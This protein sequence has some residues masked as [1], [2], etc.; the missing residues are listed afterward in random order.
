M[1]ALRFLSLIVC[2]AAESGSLR[3][4]ATLFHV[5]GDGR[6]FHRLSDNGAC[7]GRD[8]EDNNAEHFQVLQTDSLQDCREQCL[9]KL[10]GCKG[11]GYSPGRCEV[12]VR[13]DGIFNTAPL[14]GSVCERFGWPVE[15]LSEQ[16]SYAGSSNQCLGDGGDSGS[17]GTHWDY[18]TTRGGLEDCKAQCSAATVCLGIEFSPI[19]RGGYGHCKVWKRLI[20]SLRGKTD[21]RC[22]YFRDPRGFEVVT[23]ASGSNGPCRGLSPNDNNAHH[24]NLATF[25]DSWKI[26]NCRSLCHQ[27]LQT[28]KGIEF[29]KGRC[30]LWTRPEG[31]YHAAENLTAF[32]CERWGWPVKELQRMVPAGTWGA[33]RGDT[34]NDNSADYY[35]VHEATHSLDDCAARCA[36][37]PVCF[38]VEFAP[39]GGRCEVW[40][41]PIRAT[42]PVPGHEC[43]A[44]VVQG[45]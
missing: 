13:P 26:R 41:R 36:A 42:E 17:S 3:A 33:C 32:T 1:S 16:V 9:Q 6:I 14:A 45:F 20:T 38:G 40:N 2:T 27:S 4:T 37:S 12:W 10:P 44:W 30:E 29:S 39:E 25:Y 15:K 22:L 5:K 7:R 31:I 11:I 8:K 43:W 28:C 34:S 19:N 24:Y 21:T 23:S 18:H 35:Q